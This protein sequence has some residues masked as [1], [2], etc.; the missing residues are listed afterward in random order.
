MEFTHLHLHSSYSLLDGMIRLP[1]LF[2]KLKQH[3][4]KAVA[5]TDHG[6][7]FGIVDFYKQAK[8]AGIKPIIG[9]ESYICD[10]RFDRTKRQAYH[11]ILLARTNEGYKNL[12]YL[13]SMANIEGFYYSPRLDKKLLA[14]RQGGLIGMS[15]CLGGEI[16]QAVLKRGVE[17]AKE[18]AREY[19]DLFDPGCFFLEVQSNGLDEQ[20]QVN[21]AYRTIG[22]DLDIPLVATNDCHYVERA[23]AKA[24]EVLLAL[25][26]GRTLEDKKRLRH[27]VDAY[28]IKSPAEMAEHFH[29][30]PEALENTAR[31]AQMCNVEIELG[32]TYLPRYKVP[33][34]FDLDSFVEKVAREGFAKRADEAAGAGHPVDQDRYRERLEFE[35]GVIKKM[36]FSGYFLIVWDFINWA[37]DHGIPVGPGRGSGAGSLVAYSMRITDIDPLPNKLLFERFLNPE[38]VSMPDFDVDFCMNRREEV[39]EYV[40]QKYGKTSVGQIATFHQLKARGVIRDVARVLGLPHGDADKLAKLVPEPVQGKSPPLAEAIKGE[41]K[42][43]EQY[44]HDPQIRELLDYAK[45]LENLNRHAGMHAAGVVISEEPLWHY[46]PCFKGDKGEIISQYAKDEVEKVGL[47]KFDFLGLKTLTVLDIA[48]KHVNALRARLGE[49]ALTLQQIPLDD[50]E[51]YKMI[52]AG[53]T[54]GVFQIESSGFKELLKKLRPDCFEDIVAAVALYRPGPLEGGMV[55]DFIQRKHGLKKTVYQHPLLEPIL[56]D[57]YGVIVYQEQVM[58]I[59]SALAGYTLGQA[60]LLRRAMGKKKAEEMAKQKNLFAEGA[61]KKEVDPKIA[62]EVFDLMEKFAGYGFNRSHSAAYALITCQTGWLKCHYP[63]EFMAGL[64]TCDKDNTDGIVRFMAEARA[65]GIE[66]RRPDVNESESDFSVVPEG[67]KRY[68]RFGLGAVRGVG[69]QAVAAVIEA[70]TADGPFRSIFDFTRRVDL[71]RVNRRVIEAM[72]KAGAFDAVAG[73]RGPTGE[74]TGPGLKRAQVLAAIEPAMERAQAAQRDRESGQQSLF[75]ALEAPKAAGPAAA[76]GAS[77]E[78]GYTYP[79]VDWE[80]RQLLELEKEALGLY[81]SGHPLDRYASD[82]KRYASATTADLEGREERSQ[83]TIGGIVSGYRE[84]PLKSGAGRMA[85]FNLEDLNGQVEVVVFSK[86]FEKHQAVIKSGEPLLVSGMIRKE[87]DDGTRISVSLDDAL[88]LTKLRI[89]KTSQVHVVVNADIAT[90]QKLEDLR[91]LIVQHPGSCATL[92]HLRIPKRAEAVVALPAG[93]E[94][95]PTEELL[96]GVERLF[97]ERSIVLR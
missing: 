57:T 22:R 46:V 55:D 91:R 44:D 38:R 24:H 40:S 23:D 52:T 68:I 5:L 87:G 9:C 33:E 21:D 73:Q 95:A 64:L 6:Y 35:L 93:F 62:T 14:G 63:V 79:D 11:L 53:D 17:A 8:A 60:D 65:M 86:A 77:A 76:A 61:R 85:F 88:P 10:D 26:Q 59:A 45:S 29:D 71:K 13:N 81:L 96:V 84:R 25:Q 30:L 56:K 41:P 58:Q 94:V 2:P 20:E 7:L 47:V 32:K 67:E 48:M 19:R 42:L 80:P 83:V 43:Q 36:G 66:V 97:G 74:A 90:R 69:E 28:Y 49:P 37:K 1:D 89:Q 31:I 3:G 39:I 92:L 75:G 4:M 72:V 54:T 82:L 70:R 50:P 15:A 18:V 16:A 51:M 34:G 27:E 12:C 78:A